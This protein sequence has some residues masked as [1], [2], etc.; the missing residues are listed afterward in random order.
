MNL[1]FCTSKSSNLILIKVTLKSFGRKKKKNFG[2]STRLTSPTQGKMSEYSVYQQL[3]EDSHATK[4]TYKLLQLPSKILNQ[5]E[6]KTANLYIKSDINSLA[7]CTDSETFKLRQMN[8]SNTVLLLNKEPDS[9][10]I[11]FQKTSYEYELT[12]IKGSIDTSNIPIF[13]GRTV[14]QRIDLQALKDNSICSYQEFLSNWYELGGCEIDHGAYIMS[15]DIL[16]ELLYLLIT[17]LMSLQVHEFSWEDVS[18]IIAPPYNDSMLTSIIH[19]FC[20]LENEKY[21]LNDLKITQWFGIVEMSK[22]NHKMTDISEFLLNWKTSLPS[23]Y[24][25]PLDLSQL[26]GYYC[27][28][29][30]HKILYVDPESLSDNLSQ[31]FKELFELDKSWNYDEFIP[32]ISKFVPAG[33]KVDSI[34]LKYGK[35]KK[36]GKNRFVVCPR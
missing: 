7:L 32:F 35:K 28:P 8:H 18:S 9:K 10:L 13:N 22:I 16:T 33:K 25:P 14:P 17:K 20:T 23:F 1:N 30:E 19:K 26:T 36:V 31:R 29:I 21:H 12:E 15:A 5:L 34:I 11:G 3:N 6:S 27:S 4:Y 24:N 2:A